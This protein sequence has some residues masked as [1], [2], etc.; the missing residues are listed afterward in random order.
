MV[1]DITV[2]LE[3]CV[4]SSYRKGNLFVLGILGDQFVNGH[5]ENSGTFVGYEFREI[6]QKKKGSD[7][8]L[9]MEKSS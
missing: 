8:L 9:I 7:S 3:N 1:L 2:K 6:D 4:S 5:G